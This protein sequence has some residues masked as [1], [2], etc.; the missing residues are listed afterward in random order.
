MIKL[1]QIEFITQKFLFKLSS[2]NLA[3]GNAEMEEP[4][5]DKNC[6]NHT[7]RW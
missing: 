6:K 3:M 5:T 2:S 4:T 1:N 7:K